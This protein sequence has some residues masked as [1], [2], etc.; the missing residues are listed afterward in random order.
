MFDLTH[1]VFDGVLAPAE[2]QLRRLDDQQRGRRVVKEKV[3]VGLADLRQVLFRRQGY[4]GFL[5]LRALAT[6]AFQQVHRGLQV[7][8]QVGLREIAGHQ[9]VQ[10]LVDEE[11][12]VV[13]VRERVDAIALEDEVADGGLTE[14]VTLPELL[15]PAVA[16]ERVE[17]LR[18]KSGAASA[19]VE[20]RQER[21]LRVVP[22]DLRVEPG[23]ETL[24]E[25]GFSESRWPFDGEV[26]KVHAQ[27]SYHTVMRFASIGLTLVRLPLVRPF[28][29]SFG[30]M[31]AREAILVDVQDADGQV[32][33]GECVADAGPFYSAEDSATAWHVLETYL[34]PALLGQE[35]GARD[36]SHAC[37]HVRGHQMAK[38]S[39]E[40]AAWDLEARLAGKPLCE[41]LGA[42]ARPIEAGV[43]IGIQESVAALVDRV[44]EERASGYRRVKIKIKPGW[45]RDPVEAI[46]KAHGDIPLMVDANAAYT[47]A[48]AASLQALDGFGLMMIEQP[49]DYD[50]LVQHAHLQ[51]RLRTP[52]C[53]DESIHSPQAAVDALD[54]E[55]CRIINIKPGR[56]GGFSAS[57]AV[58]ATAVA[59]RVPL[60]HGGMLETGIGRAHNLHLSALPGFTL[61]GDVAASKRY[62]APDL[63]EPAID[64]RPDGTILVPAGSG[65]GVV[66]QTDRVKHATV[67]AQRFHA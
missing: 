66:P 17:E 19:G 14:E 16:R 5:A 1:Q 62:F 60:W 8:D 25:H 36:V 67:Q 21:I 39:V 4:V 34:I 28:E 51:K 46:R 15:K 7:H 37:R 11:L 9:I 33:W 59:R 6:Q 24:G 12:V 53:L 43:S 18:L 61:P 32:G 35:L 26:A 40:M 47:M 20:I 2:I 3:V 49:L 63:I 64:V 54:L 23:R 55:S 45:D 56:L 65:I 41:L 10:T 13:E 58:H 52:I 22:D 29:T 50:D 48:D 38:A 42:A 57:L 44:A 27:K 30:R 31:T